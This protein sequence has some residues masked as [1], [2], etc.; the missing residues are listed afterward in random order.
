MSRDGLFVVDSY[1]RIMHL[2]ESAAQVLGVFIEPVWR[3]CFDVLGGTDGRNARYC[4]QN[5]TAALNARRGRATGDFDVQVADEDG[6]LLVLNLS[7]LVD[8]S[9]D[10]TAILHLFSDVTRDR[11]VGRLVSPWGPQ[12]A[13]DGHQ[14]MT[15]ARTPRT[16]R[17][18]E[19]VRLRA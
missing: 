9:G 19:V 13:D 4:R 2:S 10:A 11:L 12:D 17:Q 18:M 5:C 16:R 15:C 8:G 14:P 6:R 1:Q 3:R 7:I